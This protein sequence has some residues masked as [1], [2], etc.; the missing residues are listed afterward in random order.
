M[1]VFKRF[2]RRRCL[3]SHIYSDNVSNFI[4]AN[5][6]LKTFVNSATDT[7][8]WRFRGGVCTSQK[9]SFEKNNAKC[10]FHLWGFLL[11]WCA[12]RGNPKVTTTLFAYGRHRWLWSHY[13]YHFLSGSSLKSLPELPSWNEK[14]SLTKRCIY[15]NTNKCNFWLNNFRN[16]GIEIISTDLNGNIKN[17]ILL[18]VTWY[19]YMKKISHLCFGD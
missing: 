11:N 3:C 8:L 7:T 12:N 16:T 9:I 13:T 15:D 17:P 19:C 1:N 10:Y 18:L 4:G 6:V 5:T 14:E 2:I